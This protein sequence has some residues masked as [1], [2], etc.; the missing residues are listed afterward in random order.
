MRNI[1]HLCIASY[2]SAAIAILA[3]SFGAEGAEVIG[4]VAIGLWLAAAYVWLRGVC[5]ALS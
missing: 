2:T 4:G 5:P 1:P 3:G